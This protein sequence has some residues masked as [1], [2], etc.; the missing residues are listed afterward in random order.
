MDGSLSGFNYDTT[1]Y[2]SNDGANNTPIAASDQGLKY[3]NIASL[4]G[5]GSFVSLQ[6]SNTAGR[7]QIGVI[8]SVTTTGAG[9]YTPS[10][11]F[12][13]STGASTYAER[14]RIDPSGKV[15]IGTTSP[16]ST[17]QVNG[18]IANGVSTFSGAFTCGTSAIDFSTGNT[19]VLNPSNVIAA[20]SC[21][22]TLSNVKAGGNYTVIVT[23]NA[24][25]NAVTYTFAGFTTKFLPINAAT[26]AGNDTIYTFVFTGSTLYVTWSGGYQ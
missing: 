1:A 7:A 4:D 22:V 14:M 10:I 17:L 21:A 6:G 3:S 2:V 19:Q 11:I 26:T 20:G 25:T 13:Q 8:G 9:A 12:G 18:A 24:A 16:S 15:G 23:G 5:S